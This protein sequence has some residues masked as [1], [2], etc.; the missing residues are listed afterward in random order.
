MLRVSHLSAG[1]GKGCL[2]WLAG[3]CRENVMT[4]KC[5]WTAVASTREEGS[6]ALDQWAPSSVSP[7]SDGWPQ[8]YPVPM[9]RNCGL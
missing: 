7:A 4:S 1:R 5:K 8:G 2:P 6:K 3:Q 9:H